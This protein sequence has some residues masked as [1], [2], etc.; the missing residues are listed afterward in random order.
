VVSFALSAVLV[1]LCGYLI[2]RV[3][4]NQ[5]MQWSIFGQY[6]FSRPIIDGLEV[7]LALALSSQVIAIAI[8]VLIALMSTARNPVFVWFSR[9]YVAILRAVP[10]LLQILFWYNLAIFFPRIGVGIPFT[11]LGWS[12]NSN[13]V[14][15]AFTA[16]LIALSLN[17]SAYMAEIIRGGIAAVPPSQF[18]AAQS[19]GMTRRLAYRRIILPQAARIMLPPT[20]NQFIGLLKTTSLVAIVGGGDLLTQAQRIYAA[21]YAVLPLLFVAACWYVALTAAATIL[22]SLLEARLAHES[23]DR[24]GLRRALRS[25]VAIRRSTSRLVGPGD[26]LNQ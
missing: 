5:S 23:L 22:Q 13:S 6:V 2:S 10:Q 15:G 4:T 3:L 1:F 8:G 7:T 16:C 17:E 11:H 24:S 21:N 20:G 14:I 19:L 26:G 12:A 9:G 25:A 18:E